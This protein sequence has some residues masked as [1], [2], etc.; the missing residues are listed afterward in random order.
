MNKKMF[1]KTRARACAAENS[2][3]ERLSVFNKQAEHNSSFIDQFTFMNPEPKSEYSV[4]LNPQAK[5]PLNLPIPS[6]TVLQYK[7]L[8]LH[9]ERYMHSKS[10][11]VL[12]TLLSEKRNH[13]G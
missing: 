10:I 5:L 6:Y 13:H 9:I 4:L 1:H 2:D 7:L 12:K 11:L 8:I 3:C